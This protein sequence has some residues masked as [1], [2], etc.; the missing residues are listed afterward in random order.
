MEL[1][2]YAVVVAALIAVVAFILVVAVYDVVV[3]WIAKKGDN[4][5]LASVVLELQERVEALEMRRKGE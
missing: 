4:S 1:N 2:G 5:Q 3:L